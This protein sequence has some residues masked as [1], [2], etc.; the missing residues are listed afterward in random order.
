MIRF[1]QRI[2]SVVLLAAGFA[3]MSAN[4]FAQHPYH[5]IARWPVGGEAGW[6]TLVSDSAAHRLYITHGPRVEVLDTTTGKKVGASASTT[7]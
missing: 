6:D 2:S 3:V 4:L 7:G 1:L 5:I